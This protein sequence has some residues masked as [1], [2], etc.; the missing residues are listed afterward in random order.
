MKGFT[1]I[2]QF[3]LHGGITL[4]NLQNC[5]TG[6]FSLVCGGGIRMKYQ[7]SNFFK[8]LM[9]SLSLATQPSAPLIWGGR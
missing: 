6:A 4:V 2:Q 7:E 3:L 5:F 8:D 1:L 9:I